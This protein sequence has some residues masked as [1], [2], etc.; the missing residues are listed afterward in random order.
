M[1]T[2]YHLN[3]DELTHDFFVSLQT[4]FRHK[5]ITIVVSEMNDYDANPQTL[6]EIL[7]LPADEPLNE[8]TIHLFGHEANR[9]H[10]EHVMSNAK[11]GEGMLSFTLEELEA[12]VGENAK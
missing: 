2:I 1:Q 5:S 7:G 10:L 6:H 12:L 4:L 9:R 8:S 11:K 3:A